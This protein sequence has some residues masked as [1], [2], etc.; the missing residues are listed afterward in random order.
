MELSLLVAKIIAIVYISS[1]IAVIIGQLNFEKITESLDASP[2]LTL[3]AGF[4]GIIIGFVLVEYHNIWVAN[5]TV[6]ITIIS[7]LFLIGGLVIVVLP[8]TLS[9]FSKYYKHSRFWGFFML[10]FGLLFG[11]WG[12]IS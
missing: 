12:F 6:L 8:K 11:Y 1:G 7:W 3:I 5:W 10:C 9:F 2:A 4:I